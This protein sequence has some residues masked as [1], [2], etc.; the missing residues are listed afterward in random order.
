MDPIAFKNESTIVGLDDGY[1]RSWSDKKTNF[2]LIVGKSI[3][4]KG[5]PRVLGLVSSE[6]EK[7]T[8]FIS[9]A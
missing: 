7:P 2:E 1:L 9:D 4:N 8:P 5:N 3:P 6:D